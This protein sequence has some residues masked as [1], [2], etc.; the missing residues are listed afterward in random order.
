VFGV[1]IAFG[2]GPAAAGSN[3]RS[4]SGDR[5]GRARLSETAGSTAI[6]RPVRRNAFVSRDG[7]RPNRVQSRPRFCG[8][9]ETRPT[10]AVARPP[11]KSCLGVLA[12]ACIPTRNTSCNDVG[13][14]TRHALCSE[15]ARA[16]RSVAGRSWRE[17][18]SG[19]RAS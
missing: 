8:L 18:F 16:A 3:L 9:G 10:S 5:G 11:P 7:S 13:G 19:R 6:H 1:G 4:W 14:A 2:S 17:I 12:P 15:M